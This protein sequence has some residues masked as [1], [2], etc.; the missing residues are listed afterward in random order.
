MY[1]LQA[2]MFLLSKKSKRLRKSV[3]ILST[4]LL[5]AEKISNSF[6]LQ[7]AN[8][9]YQ[10]F[11]TYMTTIIGSGTTV[12][13]ANKMR[14]TYVYGNFANFDKSDGTTPAYAAFQRNVLIAGNLL[15]GT[16]TLDGNG[17]AIDSNS[18]IQFTLNK[19]PYNI[20][21]KTL[22]YISNLTSDCQQQISNLTASSGG[23]ISS[24][25]FITQ[26]LSNTV[27]KSG[28]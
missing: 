4:I 27:W 2:T 3:I 11:I 14:S 22:S 1:A 5:F 23:N 24:V 6:M 9:K 25:G 10:Q 20:P 26:T 15:L 16:E 17:N 7:Y 19:I 28:L 18:N 13:T 12:Q 8:I 21:L